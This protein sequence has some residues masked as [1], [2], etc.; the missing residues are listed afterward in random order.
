MQMNID[1]ALDIVTEIAR[2]NGEGLLETMQY[3]DRNLFQ[4]DSQQR[5]AF[6]VAFNEFAKLFATKE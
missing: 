6:R 2:N 4:F 3:M 1:E 5:Q